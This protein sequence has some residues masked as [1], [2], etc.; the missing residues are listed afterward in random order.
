MDLKDYKKEELENHIYKNPDTYVGGCHL[1]EE[2]LPVYTDKRIEFQNDEYIPALYNTYNEI[3]VNAR[4]QIIR[5]SQRKLKGDIPVKNI[6]VDIQKET[7]EI[8]IYNDGTGIDIAYHPSELDK[9]GNKIWIPTMIFGELLTS[10]NYK[11]NEKKIVGG[12]NG[13]GAKLTNIFSQYFKLETLDSS[14]GLKYS[15]TFEDNMKTRGKPKVSKNSGKSHTKISW[16]A[17]FV[18]FGLD[19]YSKEMYQLMYGQ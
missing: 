14:R 12:K 16:T 7:G 18:R 5:I 6:K 15:Q 9:D 8:S 1:I 11:E 2:N 3:F 10:I 19:G 13:Y 17:D 4:D